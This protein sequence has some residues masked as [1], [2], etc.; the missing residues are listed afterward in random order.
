VDFSTSVT[1][2]AALAFLQTRRYHPQAEKA[3]S[4]TQR[5]V[6]SD[7]LTL[8]LLLSRV[9][10]QPP[11]HAP[12]SV[13]WYPGTAGWVIPTSLSVVALE[14][15][16]RIWKT[17]QFSATVRQSQEYL[18]SR[19]CPDGGWN[20]GGSNTRSESAGSYPETTGVALMALSSAPPE[21]L[22]APLALGEALLKNPE[23]LEGLSWLQMGLLA[24]RKIAPDPTSIRLQP[25]N[26]REAA[27]RMLALA[28]RE[29]RPTFLSESE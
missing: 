6:Y 20:H 11:A 26:A 7:H 5:Q 18:L 1:S 25:R 28:A 16:G 13:P 8:G 24:N 29:G 23:S 10:G 2:L 15:A 12:G 19:R 3:V 17:S 22:T 14:E 21:Q 9:T 27:L 4:W